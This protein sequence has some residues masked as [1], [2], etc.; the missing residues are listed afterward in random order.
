ML[1]FAQMRGI[2][3][4]SL[5][6]AVLTIAASVCYFLLVYVPS[7]ERFKD[8]QLAETS[9]RE[10]AAKHESD[11]FAQ[12]QRATEKYE[13]EISAMGSHEVITDSSNH[14]NQKS[15]ECLVRIQTLSNDGHRTFIYIEDAYESRMVQ[16]CS[17][18]FGGKGSGTVCLDGD[19]NEIASQDAD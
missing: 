9:K 3:W 15:Q 19:N 2:F 13:H 1:S 8:Q 4:L 5:S 11:C 7:R 14:Y 17:V 16:S 12:A 6:V 18:R 10:L